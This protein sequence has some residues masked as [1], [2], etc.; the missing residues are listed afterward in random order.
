MVQRSCVRSQD[1][2]KWIVN[3]LRYP[4]RASVAFY[5]WQTLSSNMSDSSR[6][7]HT[8]D[9]LLGPEAEIEMFS[10]FTRSER[11]QSELHSFLLLLLYFW[12]SSVSVIWLL[13][14]KT[15]RL[16]TLWITSLLSQLYKTKGNN[17]AWSCPVDVIVSLSFLVRLPPTQTGS[18]PWEYNHVFCILVYFCYHHI[19][20]AYIFCLLCYGTVNADVIFCC[21]WLLFVC[22]C[23][24]LFCFLFACFLFCFVFVCLFVLGLVLP[25]LLLLLLLLCV[26]VC[27][28]VC[29]IF[30][31]GV[32][33]FVS[34]RYEYHC[35]LGV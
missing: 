23:L 25:L 1:T 35:W 9:N 32:V 6:Q 2:R 29:F 34:W 8:F 15:G 28:F 27:F 16:L 31:W 7:T 18:K 3:A 20:F 21:C 17:R 12:C 33:F 30:V 5:G 10:K 19:I 22:S 14:D 11:K 24:L 13:P 4:D 26:C